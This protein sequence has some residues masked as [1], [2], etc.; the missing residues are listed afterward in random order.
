M[1]RAGDR[2]RVPRGAVPPPWII[3]GLFLVTT[4]TVLVVA[5][6]TPDGL[7]VRRAACW[8]SAASSRACCDPSRQIYGDWEQE[9]GSEM[10]IIKSVPVSTRAQQSARRADAGRAAA[11]RAWRPATVDVEVMGKSNV[12]AIAYTTRDPQVAHRACDA[13]DPRLHRLPPGLA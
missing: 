10:Q 1:P 7:H 5:L 2:P 13:A 12:I 3:L 6:T 9:L 11:A 8:S 4:A